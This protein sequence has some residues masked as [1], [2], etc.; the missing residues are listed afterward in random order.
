[1]DRYR[2]ILQSSSQM[3]SLLW[4]L[5]HKN[6]VSV[7]SVIAHAVLECKSVPC[8]LVCFQCAWERQ[9]EGACRAACKGIVCCKHRSTLFSEA[10]AVLHDFV[11]VSTLF[12]LFQSFFLELVSS[13]DF[14]DA[15]CLYSSWLIADLWDSDSY[16]AGSDYVLA[17]LCWCC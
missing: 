2:R 6:R 13:G 14:F 3:S 7:V 12:D 15:T 9:E 10:F 4:F 11:A 17:R 16:F 8:V 5:K 1:M